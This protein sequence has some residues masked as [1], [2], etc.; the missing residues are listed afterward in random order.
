MTELHMLRMLK[1][2][3]YTIFNVYSGFLF[4]VRYMYIKDLI[5]KVSLFRIWNVFLFIHSDYKTPVL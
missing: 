3:K 5:H 1:S 2:E 4:S